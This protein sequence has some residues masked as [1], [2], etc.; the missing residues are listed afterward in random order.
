MIIILTM[1]KNNI[2]YKIKVGLQL[3][4]LVLD[5]IIFTMIKKFRPT[6]SSVGLNLYIL[7]SL[8]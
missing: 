7:V 1:I 5:M 2:A 6:K 4:I 3:Y 8:W